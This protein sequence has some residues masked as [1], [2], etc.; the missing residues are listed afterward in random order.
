MGFQIEQEEP[1]ARVRAP[2]VSSRVSSP[3][4][5]P[6]QQLEQWRIRTNNYYRNHP[7]YRERKKAQSRA[8]YRE[9]SAEL[10]AKRVRDKAIINAVTELG[11][12]DGDDLMD[13]I[14]LLIKV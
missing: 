13:S 4:L 5:S 1:R 11:L 14:R 6:E 12:L 10:L 9:K 2:R 8:R 3:K 7:D